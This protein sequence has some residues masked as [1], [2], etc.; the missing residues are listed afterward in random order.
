MKKKIW[1]PIV[2]V[3]LLAI[4]VTPIPTGVYNDGG[5]REYTA[6]TYKVVDWNRLTVMAPRTAQ[7]R[8]ISSLITSVPLI[9][10]GTKRS[11]M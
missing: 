4:L 7:L 11:R 8:Y 1:I 3:A 2:I 5:T 6:L 9:T 10:Y